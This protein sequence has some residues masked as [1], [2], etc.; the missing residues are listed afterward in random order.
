MKALLPILICS[1]IS[2]GLGY[3]FGHIT[4][5]AM[6]NGSA[7]GTVDGSVEAM[8]LDSTSV[9]PEFDPQSSAL[10]SINSE[11]EPEAV[12]ELAV[13]ENEPAAEQ[14][15]FAERA[16]LRV[17]TLTDAQGRSIQATIIKVLEDSVRIRRSDGLETTIP[18]N[19]LSPEDVAFCNY[20]RENQATQ[21]NIEVKTPPSS[22]EFDWDAYFNS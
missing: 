15:D 11:A 16:A 1:V 14:S 12:A 4:V 18:L 6:A 7:K 13:P 3:Y 2:A 9:Q 17:Q 10:S 5:P 19:L 20:L 21:E 8:A 22:G